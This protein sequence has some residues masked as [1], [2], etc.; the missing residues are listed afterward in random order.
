[1]EVQHPTHNKNEPVSRERIYEEVWTVGAALR[2]ARGFFRHNHLVRL[3][4][5]GGTCRV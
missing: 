3:A 1:M 4:D 5:T 2:T